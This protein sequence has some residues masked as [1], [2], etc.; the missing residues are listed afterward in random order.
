MLKES[1]FKIHMRW[2]MNTEKLNRINPKSPKICW[3]CHENEG[4][5][6]HLWWGCKKSKE[7][8]KTL[9]ETITKILGYEINKLPALYLLGLRMEGIPTKDRTLLWYML[10]AARIVYAKYWKNEEIPEL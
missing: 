1:I 7:Y 6:Y 4:T 5:M 9:H 8:W 3:K 2:Y 10:A